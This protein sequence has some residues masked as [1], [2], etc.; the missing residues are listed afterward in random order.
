MGFP[1]FLQ[2]SNKCKLFK[3]RSAAA[4]TLFTNV[5]LIY[6]IVF[7]YLFPMVNNSIQKILISKIYFDLRKVNLFMYIFTFIKSNYSKYL[8]FCQVS[9]DLFQGNCME[10]AGV[11]PKIRLKQ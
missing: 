5:N 8:D 10:F 3:G 1:N 11:Q 9:L 2:F 7:I 6:Q 4:F